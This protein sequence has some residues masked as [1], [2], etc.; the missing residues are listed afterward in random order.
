L[1]K[2]RLLLTV[3]RSAWLIES[4]SAESLLPLLGRYM[5]GERVAFFDD[6]E[7]EE[8]PQPYAV[9]RVM[10]LESNTFQM[11]SYSTYDE[12]PE[13]SIAVIPFSG[14][15]FK[16]D[17]CGTPGS[18][19]LSRW[20]QDADNHPNI[21]A[22]IISMDSGGGTVDGTF[23]CAD[24]VFATQKPLVSW[25]NGMACSAAYGIIS[26]S[27]LIVACHE[28]AEIGSI[29]TAIKVMDSSEAMTK[30]GYKLHYVTAD[31]SKD[32]NKAYFEMLKGNYDLIKQESLNPTNDV[33]LS[34]VKRNREGK[35]Q[36]DKNNEPLTGKVYLAKA[37]IDNGLVD[38]IGTLEY[39]I[40]RAQELAES[41][42]STPSKSNNMFGNKYPKMSALKGKTADQ[43]T[44]EDINQVNEEL[45]AAG[46]EGITVVNAQVIEAAEQATADLTA[47]NTKLA[48]A[49][50]QVT[51]LTKERDEAQ[52]LADKY[53]KQSGAV[54]TNPRLEG[55]EKQ[56]TL[57]ETSQSVIDN[58]PHNKALDE[59]PLFAG[60]A[61]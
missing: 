15:I 41:S 27:N 38:E 29:G 7:E 32:K 45:S 49:T 25:I 10:D 39:A 59:N 53:G 40:S 50:T 22:T 30:Y 33:F 34:T 2:H 13:G 4:K 26:G 54:P 17:Y 31:D 14:T 52:A 16:E 37:A 20:V 42:T 8:A 56:E 18:A 46:I 57:N 1:A 44:L 60:Q 5:A 58:L 24:A 19:T 47:A 51:Q 11:K 9:C 28:V 3:F 55:Q 6:D 12:A 43:I 61:K 21:A 48:T 35:L 36:L 23:E